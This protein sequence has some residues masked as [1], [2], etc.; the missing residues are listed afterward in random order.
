MRMLRLF[1]GQATAL[2]SARPAHGSGWPWH[3]AGCVAGFERHR[4]RLKD[5]SAY[6]EYLAHHADQLQ[7]TGVTD[8]IVDAIGVFAGIQNAL[9][10]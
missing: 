7:G 8:P 4:D 5:G 9:V 2:T 10:A 1:G 3:V 6:A